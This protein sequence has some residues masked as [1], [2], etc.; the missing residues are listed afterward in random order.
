MSI[1]I[2]PPVNINTI[3]AA[4]SWLS[5]LYN[6]IISVESSD[7]V[8]FLQTG[9]GSSP[10]TVQSRLR[11]HVSVR[12][13]GATGNGTTDDT[14]AIQAAVDSITYGAIYFP[15][16]EYKITSEIDITKANGIRIYGAGKQITYI[17]LY[18]ANQNGF[19]IGQDVSV[20]IEDLTITAGSGVTKNAGAGIA[21]NG[22]SAATYNSGS[23]FSNL[24]VSLQYNGIVFGDAGAFWVENCYILSNINTGV[25]VRNSVDGDI[26]DGLIC[27]CQFNSAAATGPGIAY[28]SGGGLRVISNKFWDH[29][30]GGLVLDLLDDGDTGGL[31]ALGNSFDS[32]GGY[33]ILLQN[34]AAAHTFISVT[35]VGNQFTACTSADIA[36]S[37]DAWL[38]YLSIVGNNFIRSND[39]DSIEING[40]DHVTISGNVFAGQGGTSNAITIGGDTANLNIPPTNAFYNFATNVTNASETSAFVTLKITSGTAAPIAGA[41]LRGDICWNTEPAASGVPGWVC[42][43]AGT[44]G[45]WKA[46]AALA[47]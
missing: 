18:T 1:S 37:G 44:P 16:G 33:G 29:G 15:P 36:Q 23:R 24:I 6:W 34:T 41:W 22:A 14:A 32:Q 30:T 46:M 12:D 5:Q 7:G 4:Q 27:H 35:I 26:G 3:A 25:V 47:A 31:F 10:R 40:A 38:T 43:T 21:V 13:F 17:V 39:S 9:T 42:T 45:T 28:S 20:I 11:D 8:N 2:G 19:N